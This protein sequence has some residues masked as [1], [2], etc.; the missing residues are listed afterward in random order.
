MGTG[1]QQVS[2]ATQSSVACGTTSSAGNL[3]D[4]IQS[5]YLAVVHALHCDVH[6]AVDVPGVVEQVC[7]FVPWWLVCIQLGNYLALQGQRPLSFNPPIACIGTAWQPMRN[8]A[9]SMS[10]MADQWSPAT[11]HSI[12]CCNRALS[13]ET[14]ERLG[15]P[16]SR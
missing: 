14:G 7:K 3:D 13:K 10:G 11:G 16:I 4:C 9:Q 8:M 6:I 12:R 2:I 15:A 1:E 5:S